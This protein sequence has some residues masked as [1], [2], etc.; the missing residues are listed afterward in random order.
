M[1]CLGKSSGTGI[2]P[3]LFCLGGGAFFG[4]NQPRTIIP[5]GRFVCSHP[6]LPGSSPFP[7]CKNPCPL[8]F[9]RHPLIHVVVAVEETPAEGFGGEGDFFRHD[10]TQHAFP[11]MWTEKL[12]ARLERRLGEEVW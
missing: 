9:R 3:P 11:P 2:F 1:R 7:V 4:G 10:V 8:V 6:F 12:R 5:R